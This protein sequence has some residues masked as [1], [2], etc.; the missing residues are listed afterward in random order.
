MKQKIENSEA[1][2]K[3]VL[4]KSTGFSAPK[5]YFSSAE[6]HFSS[7]LIEK[8]LSKEN[9]FTIPENYFEEIESSLIEKIIFK[10]EV[11]VISFK[12]KLI[13]YIPITAAASIALFLSVNYLTS[14]DTKEIN[15]DALGNT[16]I[17][18]WIVENSNEL[19]DKDF[20]AILHSEI[21]NEND[22]A[23]T[24]LQSD[25]IEEYIINIEESSLLNENY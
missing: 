11:K 9:G 18:N 22:F 25:A 7:F 8:E 14:F 17:E 23:I 4:H 5:N 24:D 13:K 3:T 1:F 12:N 16:D 21:S 15:F 19:S 6:D 2:L 20:V 10:K